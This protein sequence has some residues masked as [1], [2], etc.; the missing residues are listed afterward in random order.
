[1][2]RWRR[3]HPQRRT[4]KRRTTSTQIEAAARAHTQAQHALAGGT[5]PRHWDRHRVWVVCV[6]PPRGRSL[7]FPITR[8]P[9]EPVWGPRRARLRIREKLRF[10]HPRPHSARMRA[11]SENES[12]REQDGGLG[13]GEVGW[14]RAEEGR[15]AEQSDLLSSPRRIINQV[16]R[17]PE[18][19]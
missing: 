15:A 9:T 7:R 1:V 10:R 13:V 2:A 16:V 14:G 4:R 17:F 5:K 6:S 8:A 18:L 19:Q 3:Q 11:R 12:V